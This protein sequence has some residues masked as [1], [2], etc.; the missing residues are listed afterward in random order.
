MPSR[1]G[2][3]ARLA[4]GAV[5]LMATVASLALRHAQLLH[6]APDAAHAASAAGVVYAY[7][8]LFALMLAAQAALRALRRAGGPGSEALAARVAAV[9]FHVLPAMVSVR[10]LRRRGVPHVLRAWR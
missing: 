4:W 9:A 3:A 6:T 1:H 10:L 2:G 8:A 5:P 7:G